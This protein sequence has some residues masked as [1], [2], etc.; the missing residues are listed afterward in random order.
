MMTNEIIAELHGNVNRTLVMDAIHGR[1][2]RDRRIRVP[3]YIPV[4]SE[5]L[6]IKHSLVKNYLSRAE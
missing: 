2:K 3:D 5:C 4:V 1:A 6:F